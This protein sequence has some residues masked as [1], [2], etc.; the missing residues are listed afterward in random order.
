MSESFE[1]F[2][3]RVAMG[4][5]AAIENGEV[6]RPADV[7]AE[8]ERAVERLTH[9]YIERMRAHDLCVS[10]V[11]VDLIDVASMAGMRESVCVRVRTDVRSR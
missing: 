7:M 1:E 9:A 5:Q 2:A 11:H 6:T 4:F 10:D 3:R 8:Y